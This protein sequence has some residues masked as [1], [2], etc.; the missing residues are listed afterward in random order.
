MYYEI[1]IF[2]TLVLPINKESSE[3]PKERAS[4]LCSGDEGGV[5]KGDSSLLYD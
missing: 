1:L 4:F 2:L 5:N 3:V